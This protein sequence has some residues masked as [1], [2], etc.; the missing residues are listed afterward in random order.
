MEWFSRM[1]LS[2]NQKNCSWTQHYLKGNIVSNAKRIAKSAHFLRGIAPHSLRWIA[3]DSTFLSE[4]RS[5]TFVSKVS[6]TIPSFPRFSALPTSF[7]QGP[8][9]QATEIGDFVS[10]SMEVSEEKIS[11]FSQIAHYWGWIS[12]IGYVRSFIFFSSQR[13]AISSKR[14]L[15]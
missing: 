13:S 10:S 8:E 12:V 3:P 7:G 15:A 9:A 14:Q 2:R 5:Q 11:K 1:I 6:Q 4:A